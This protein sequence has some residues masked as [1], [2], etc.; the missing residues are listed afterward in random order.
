MYVLHGFSCFLIN[1]CIH[2]TIW[3][4][5]SCFCPLCCF[6]TFWNIFSLGCS[7]KVA[8]WYFGSALVSKNASSAIALYA[9]GTH[10]LVLPSLL[11]SCVVKF[12]ALRCY[13]CCFASIVGVGLFLCCVDFTL[14]YYIGTFFGVLLASTL[15][16]VLARPLI[17]W[18]CL[19]LNAYYALFNL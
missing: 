6:I 5:C 16:A 19:P 1:N 17:L 9:V 12:V 2:I 14:G 15:G 8:T 3:C 4:V 18:G 11:F 7:E 13:H 10:A